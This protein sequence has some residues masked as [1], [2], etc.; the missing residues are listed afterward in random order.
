MQVERWEGYEL[1]LVMAM[2]TGCQWD[3]ATL[4]LKSEQPVMIELLA[5]SPRII[6]VGPTPPSPPSLPGLP[7]CTCIG[8]LLRWEPMWQYLVKVQIFKLTSLSLFPSKLMDFFHMPKKLNGLSDQGLNGLSDRVL[9]HWFPMEKK[10]HA[11]PDK[12]WRRRG[13]EGRGPA[14]WKRD[15]H[16]GGGLLCTALGCRVNFCTRHSPSH[17]KFLLN[18][19]TTRHKTEKCKTE[20]V[21]RQKAFKMPVKW[22]DPVWDD[23]SQI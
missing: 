21:K 10:S 23:L 1:Q 17:V 12:Q 11:S 18:F 19:T 9:S 16:R 4:A 6:V 7:A 22:Q 5:V 13:M 3:G 15:L 2:V 8:T 14:E 20:S